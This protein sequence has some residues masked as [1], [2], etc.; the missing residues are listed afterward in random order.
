MTKT[1]QLD[2]KLDFFNGLLLQMV[3]RVEEAIL[4]ATAAVRDQNTDLAEKVVAEDYFIDQLR[5]MIENDSVRLLISEAPYGHYMRYVI[6]GLKMVTSLERMGDHAAHLASIAS[7]IDNDN[8]VEKEIVQEIVKMATSDAEMFR[9]AIE[10][11][12]KKDSK[13]AIEVSAMDD[14][15]DLFRVNINEMIFSQG[16]ARNR[17]MYE[18]FY[19]VKELERIGDHI[20]TICDWIV[21]MTDGEKPC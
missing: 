3:T 15:I 4:K 1:V 19:I 20:T 17:N 11:L 13:K 9:K 21:Y 14:E 12:I 8:T 7:R 16:D 18:Y 10:S 6:A 5:D 2:E